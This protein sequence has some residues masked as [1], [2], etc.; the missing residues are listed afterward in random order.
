[1]ALS[2][3]Q[4]DHDI[5]RRIYERGTVTG[6][7]GKVQPLHSAI[8]AREGAFLKRIVLSDPS[9]RK[10]L[11]VGCAFGLSSLHICLATVDR[12]GADHTIIDPEQNKSWDGVGIKNLESAGIDFF[13]LIEAK[14][15]FALPQLLEEDEGEFDLVFIDGWHTFD[16]TLLDCFYATRLL[17]VGGYLVIDDLDWASVSRAVAFLR[18]YPCYQVFDEVADVSPPSWKQTVLRVI[19]A[20]VP[21]RVLN[22]LLNPA[23]YRRLFERRSARMIALKKISEDNRGWD[24]H[25]D[26][27]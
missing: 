16:H 6:S 5:I 14:S 2:M 24:W 12:L 1:V 27:F 23:L 4:A 21:R 13:H 10:T 18:C 15:E 11:E 17:R 19:L 22:R 3:T 25:D 7:S 26:R 9:V 8:D 20:P